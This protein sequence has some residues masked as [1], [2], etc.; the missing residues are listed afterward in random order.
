MPFI[1]IFEPSRSR[2]AQKLDSFAQ[3]AVGWHYGAGGP[4]EQSVIDLARQMYKTA[5]EAGF[6]QTDAFAGAGREILLT[7]YHREH[8]LGITIEPDLSVTLNYEVANNDVD[9]LEKRPVDEIKQ[10]VRE[11]AGNVLWSTSDSYIPKTLIIPKDSST[12]WS[13]KNL[14]MAPECLSSN[15]SVLETRAAT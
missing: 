1:P 14:P 8:Y 12:I 9:F 7:V 11:I 6:T 3:L 2:T 4:I 10:K 5:F 13:S 15:W